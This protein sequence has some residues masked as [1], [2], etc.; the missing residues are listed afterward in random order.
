MDA[1]VDGAFLGA[2]Q[3][4]LTGSPAPLRA[5]K[6]ESKVRRQAL[7]HNRRSGDARKAKEPENKCAVVEDE[8]IADQKTVT[9]RYRA[10][11][12][13]CPPK[14]PAQTNE[15]AMKLKVYA[16]I[17]CSETNLESYAELSAAALVD[18]D[19][20]HFCQNDRE[21]SVIVNVAMTVNSLEEGANDR[22]VMVVGGLMSQDFGP[23]VYRVEDDRRYVD[24]CTMRAYGRLGEDVTAFEFYA[25]NGAGGSAKSSGFDQGEGTLTV[26]DWHGSMTFAPD[27]AATYDLTNGTESVQ[28]KA[29]FVATLKAGLE[30]AGIVGPLS[31]G[32]E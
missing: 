5:D 21:S 22:P 15:T 28:G 18:Q 6:V 8:V 29:G 7:F 25:L 3:F 2:G 19:V 26:N 31:R 23:C 24:G 17:T 27:T 14:D 11:S 20:W 13:A 9:V 1:S 16:Q 12:S 4:E 32:L 30:P 10:D